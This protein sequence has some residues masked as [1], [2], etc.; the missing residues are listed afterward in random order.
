MQNLGANRVYYGQLEKSQ[1]EN[2]FNSR[3]YTQIH[4]PSM[5]QGE[6]REGRGAVVDG[7]RFKGFLLKEK[8]F[9]NTATYQKSEREGLPP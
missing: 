4:T 2:Y 1:L 5:V 3:T 8:S 9:R 7:T 6:V